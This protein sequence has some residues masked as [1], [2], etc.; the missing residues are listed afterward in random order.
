MLAQARGLRRTFLAVDATAAWVL[1]ERSTT[2]KACLV[3]PREPSSL[4]PFFLVK[5]FSSSARSSSLDGI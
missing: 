2:A 1:V 4:Q 3:S 5:D